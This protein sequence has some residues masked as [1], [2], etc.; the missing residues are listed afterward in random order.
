MERY[1]KLN[2]QIK[3]EAELREYKNKLIAEYGSKG[4][5]LK[6]LNLIKGS[7]K[8]DLER[9]AKEIEETYLTIKGDID[10]D[11]AK[12]PAEGQESTV[13]GLGSLSQLS[14]DEYF[15]LREQGKSPDEI[16]KIFKSKE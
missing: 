9:S 5:P 12:I 11:M 2:E 1:K 8:E 15:K 10:R 4:I 7:S 3:Y 14:T 16:A 13:S 6:M